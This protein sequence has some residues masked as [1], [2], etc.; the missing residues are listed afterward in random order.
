MDGEYKIPSNSVSNVFE[1]FPIHHFQASSN[2]KISWTYF[3]NEKS[4]VFLCQTVWIST[5]PNPEFNTIRISQ[6]VLIYK[7]FPASSPEARTLAPVRPTVLSVYRPY[8]IIFT[9]THICVLRHINTYMYGHTYMI[10][11]ENIN[12]K[13]R[14]ER[15]YPA[16]NTTHIH[17]HILQT[18]LPTSIVIKS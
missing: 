5:Q 2:K 16:R 8:Q 18:L 14:K 9:D 6:V 4:C 1:S 11:T 13:K 12:S 10:Y 17:T 15:L 3:K 7:E